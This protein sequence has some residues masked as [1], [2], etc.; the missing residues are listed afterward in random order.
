[1]K[2]LSDLNSPKIAYRL[3]TVSHGIEM[4]HVQIPLK[5][6]RMFESEFH[7]VKTKTDVLNLVSS[8]NGKV[9]S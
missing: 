7:N 2:L 1:M 3:Y 4:F 5:E 8:L 9:R 6:S